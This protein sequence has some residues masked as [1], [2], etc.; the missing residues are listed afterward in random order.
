MLSAYS[1]FKA[2][3]IPYWIPGSYKLLPNY[4]KCINNGALSKE[5]VNILVE[6][7]QKS[8]LLCVFVN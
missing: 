1:C 7:L 6:W 2:N 3:T 4:F 5:L 8:A